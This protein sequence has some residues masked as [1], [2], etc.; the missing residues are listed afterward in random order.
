MKKVSYFI[1]LIVVFLINTNVFALKK[2]VVSFSDCVDG[3]TAKLVLGKEEIKVR[4]LA[5]DTPE[6]VHPTKKVEPY[7]KEASNYTCNSLKNAKK[8][9]IEYDSNSDK[10]DKY[11]RHLVWIYVDGKLLQKELISKGYAEVAYLYGD[12]S[13]TDEL[14]KAEKEAKSKKI[15]IW[16][17]EKVTP[18]QKSKKENN[19]DKKNS[20]VDMLLNEVFKFFENLCEKLLNYIADMV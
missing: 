7:G 2:E 15:G 6:S 8:I 12:Y 19:I 13:Y 14:K 4:F 17:L 18:E 10:T 5:V 20:I 16:S 11:K 3:D 9:E 1:L